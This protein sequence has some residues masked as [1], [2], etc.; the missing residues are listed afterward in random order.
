[1]PEK[2]GDS[3]K[4]LTMDK[5]ILKDIYILKLNILGC[6]KISSRTGTLTEE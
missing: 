3:R 6:D 4:T 2:S 1:M 5:N